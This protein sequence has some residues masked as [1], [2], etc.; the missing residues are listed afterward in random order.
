M[1]PEDGFVRVLWEAAAAEEAIEKVVGAAT[2][3]VS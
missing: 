2:D 3:I 1:A